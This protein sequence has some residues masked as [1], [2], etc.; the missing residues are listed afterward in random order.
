M[1]MTISVVKNMT[2]S[3]VDAPRQLLDMTITPTEVISHIWIT[4]A[5][6]DVLGLPTSVRICMNRKFNHAPREGLRK[7]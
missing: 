1:T 5:L 7:R 6:D 3:I 4:A 2:Y